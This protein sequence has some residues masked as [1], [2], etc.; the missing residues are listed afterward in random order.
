MTLIA[1]GNGQYEEKP[2]ELKPCPFCHDENRIR[3]LEEQIEDMK[4]CCIC[5]K[6]NNCEVWKES[7][8]SPIHNVND[9]PC[10]EW[11]LG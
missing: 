11:E 6:L 10:E 4:S 5:G 8:T 3:E 2:V 9:A 1:L 7:A